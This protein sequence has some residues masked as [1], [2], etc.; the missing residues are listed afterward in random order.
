MLNPLCRSW[1]IM[2]SGD[3]FGIEPV[4]ALQ[5]H[6]FFLL[7]RGERGL[8][9]L[10]G[11]SCSVTVAPGIVLV[12]FLRG[13]G[14]TAV[15][16]HLGDAVSGTQSPKWSDIS[17]RAW[18][19]P[20]WRWARQSPGLLWGGGS[21]EPAAAADGRGAG[22]PSPGERAASCLFPFPIACSNVKGKITIFGS[23]AKPL[24]CIFNFCA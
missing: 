12:R 2:K 7:L 4:S 23:I 9:S 20:V 8:S 16:L 6:D 3:Y 1:S 15:D 21:C 18:F 5:V 13:L 17:G 22:Q 10:S 14:A 19:S 24:K 11:S